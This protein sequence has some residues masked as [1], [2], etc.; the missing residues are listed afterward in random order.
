MSPHVRLLSLALALSACAPAAGGTGTASTEQATTMPPG[1]PTPPGPAP[2]CAPPACTDP[3]A[4]AGSYVSIGT[5]P[6]PYPIN[7]AS[8]FHLFV[9]TLGTAAA[10]AGMDRSHSIGH[11]LLKVR[12][13]TDAPTYISQ[14]GANGKEAKQFW[15]VYSQGPNYLFVTQH[16]G[17]LYSDEEAKADWDS[18]VKLQE[19]LEGG[20]YTTDPDVDKLP[21][22]VWY[23]SGMGAVKRAVRD[24][25]PA[26]RHRFVRATI[27]ITEA[28]CRAILTWRDAYVRTG[29]SS[30][31]SVHRAP[32]IMDSHARYDGGGCASVGFAGAFYAAGLD[33]Q[34]AARRV[35]ERLGIGTSRLTASLVRDPRKPD[36]WYNL[37]NATRY[38]PGNVPCAQ[39]GDEGCYGDSLS[40]DDDHWKA[41]QGGLIGP[42]WN[43]VPKDT[44]GTWSKLW[45]THRPVAASIVP[46][47]VFE[48]ERF[49]QEVLARWNNPAHDAFAYPGWCKLD[50]K[51]PTIVLDARDL[52]GAKEAKDGRP[53][54]IANV[55]P[56]EFVAD[57]QLP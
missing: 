56:G 7:W 36:A 33:Y 22:K 55:R 30:R 14:T 2:V 1:S 4:E 12:C 31:Y 26:T 40:W 21:G 44:S 50:G 6:A 16:D 29:G 35:T 25:A 23:L 28:Q 32:W 9:T 15:D 24:L 11:V 43:K 42:L 48:P 57:V 41:W 18:A 54:G 20:T 47:I 49:Y 51:V 46:L 19:A 3:E 13:G 8:P 39:H 17:K 38:V 53:R 5:M 27:R 52:R 10:S 37:H 45:G 34:A